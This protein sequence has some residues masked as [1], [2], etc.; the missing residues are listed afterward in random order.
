M[1]GWISVKD[2]R[3]ENGKRVLY[4]DANYGKIDKSLYDYDCFMETSSAFHNVTHWMPLPELPN[5]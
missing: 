2:K 3:P 1:T 5:E 4:Y